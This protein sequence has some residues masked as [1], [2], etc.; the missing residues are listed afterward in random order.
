MRENTCKIHVSDKVL[1]SRV[2]LSLSLYTYI[3]VIKNEVF[4][5]GMEIEKPTKK[6]NRGH[7]KRFLYFWNSLW[8]DRAV[9][10]EEIIQIG[11]PYKKRK[12]GLLH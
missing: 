8:Q 5:I 7:F 1:V 3:T 9:E 12:C 11:Y 6:Q 10:K 2:F 4:C